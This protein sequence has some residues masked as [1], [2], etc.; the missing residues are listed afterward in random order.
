MLH[1]RRKRKLSRR[2]GH[3]LLLLTNLSKVLIEHEHIKTTL[4]KAKTLRS[5]VEKLVTIG[6]TSSLH[7]RR[8]LLSKLGGSSKEVNKL[9]DSISPKFK[10]RKGGYT[11]IVKAGFRLGDNA[12]MAYIQFVE[13]LKEKTVK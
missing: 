2:I 10:D 1:K 11:R 3:R 9:L 13:G 5:F 8:K 4:A 12:P 7:S 6:K